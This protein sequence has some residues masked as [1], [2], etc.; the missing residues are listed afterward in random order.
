MINGRPTGKFTATRGVRQ[1]DPLSP[2]LFTLIIDVLSRLM[3]KAQEHNLI[4][5]MFTRRDRV[6]VSHLQ[7]ADDTIFLIG[8]KEEYW[9]NLLDLLD[10][11]CLSSGM[12]INK[13]KCS[14]VGIGRSSSYLNRL[15]GGWGC[16]VGDWPMKYL[17]LPLGGNP[18]A[19]VFWD[20]VLEKIQRRLQKW[21]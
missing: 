4:H 8:D 2:F 14:L 10:I 15:A 18:R 5:G 19:M 3:E 11:F 9:F 21:K 7:F 6:E 17:G 1:G 12:K 13:S 20:P 16:E